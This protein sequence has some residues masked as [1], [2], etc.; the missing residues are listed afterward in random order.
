MQG[1][2]LAWGQ[3]LTPQHDAGFVKLMVAVGYLEGN[4]QYRNGRSSENKESRK[5]F[6]EAMARLFP[7]VRKRDA[8]D[9]YAEVR[10]G[11]FHDGITK[12]RVKLDDQLAVA[13][14]VREKEFFV[15]PNKFLVKIADDLEEYVRQLNDSANTTLRANFSARWRG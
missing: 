2:F 4:Q 15:S 9:F 14:E 3:H 7:K 11:L 1:W 13:L 10:C 5:F 6:V 8:K 12:S